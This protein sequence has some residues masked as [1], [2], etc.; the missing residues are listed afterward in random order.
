[1]KTRHSLAL[2]II[3]LF[4]L[5][6]PLFLTGCSGTGGGGTS[7]TAGEML[8]ADDLTAVEAAL[9]ADRVEAAVALEPSLPL[10]VAP[11]VLKADQ[12]GSRTVG[13]H[14]RQY[15]GNR[16]GNG[17]LLQRGASGCPVLIA[18]ETSQSG[19]ATVGG[20]AY[21]IVRLASGGFQI[22]RPNGET[23]TLSLPTGDSTA[24]TLSENG[25]T[26]SV[27]FG[28]QA[29]EP[30]ATLTNLRSGRILQIIE[31]DAGELTVTVQGSPSGR[32]RWNADGT[33]EITSIPG[34]SQFRH[35]HGKSL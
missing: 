5:F 23:F 24:G 6:I 21:D 10:S 3:T 25:R 16:N 35:R 26:W 2:I 29:G 28:T 31:D 20:L 9:L 13:F 18:S 15:R 17:V 8:T 14:G 32:G 11:A 7:G 4:T 34:Q 22:T 30:L 12:A 27:Q 1:M 19:W 33:L